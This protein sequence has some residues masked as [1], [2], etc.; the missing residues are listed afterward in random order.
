MRVR[1]TTPAAA[2]SM[3]RDR[4]PA[5][6]APAPRREIDWKMVGDLLWGEIHE[7]A[8]RDGPPPARV[9]RLSAESRRPPGTTREAPSPT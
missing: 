7:L 8:P 1:D 6:G 4:W 9:V 2:A 5:A 3:S